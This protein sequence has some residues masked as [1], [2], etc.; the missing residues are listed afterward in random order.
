MAE[1]VLATQRRVLGPEHPHTL[2][3]MH[4]L[5]AMKAQEDLVGASKL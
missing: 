4:N 1:E 2:T 3:S 5:A